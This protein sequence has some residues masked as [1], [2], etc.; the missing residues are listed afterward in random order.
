MKIARQLVG[1]FLTGGTAAIVDVTAFILLVDLSLHII[2]AAICSFAAAAVVNYLLSS[3]FVFK[4]EP[5]SRRFLLFLGAALIGLAVNVSITYLKVVHFD[6]T[7]VLAKCVGI[8]TA[9]LVNFTMN[10]I[11]VFKQ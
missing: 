11:F 10:R 6:L 3:R 8:G 4:S 7:P 5:S 2:P 9:F 1:Y